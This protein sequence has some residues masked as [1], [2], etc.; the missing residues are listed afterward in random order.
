[1]KNIFL[2]GIDR[3]EMPIAHAEGRFATASDEFLAELKQNDQIAA[4][5]D[6]P[7]SESSVPADDDTLLP[8]PLN[9]N[10][11]AANIAGIGDP[12]GRVLGLMPHPE[13]FL[14]ATHHPQWTRHGLRGE[15]EGRKLFQNAIDYFK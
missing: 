12:S 8:Y 1:E 13:R 6:R 11:S 5:Y 14:F 9:P 10:G 4:C 7:L 3:I 15:G 2:R